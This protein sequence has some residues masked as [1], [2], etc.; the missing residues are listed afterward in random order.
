MQEQYHTL[1]C[2]YPSSFFLSSANE[3]CGCLSFLSHNVL[4]SCVCRFHSIPMKHQKKADLINVVQSDF[5]RQTNKL[6]QFSTPELMQCVPPSAGHSTLCFL[7]ACQFIHYQYGTKVASQL[8]CSCTCW[9]PPKVA[10]DSIVWPTWVETLLTQLRSRLGKVDTGIIKTCCD[11]YLM[12][13]PT[14]KQKTKRYDLIIQQFRASQKQYFYKVGK[15]K[16][17]VKGSKK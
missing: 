8:L 3:F 13:N 5:A 9:N 14:P 12:P 10:N 15:V 16:K 4:F 7:L 2:T 11:L 6:I 17:G 1:D